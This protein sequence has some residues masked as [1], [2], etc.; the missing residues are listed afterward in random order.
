MSNTGAKYKI[1]DQQEFNTIRGLQSFGMTSKKIQ[2]HL[3]NNRHTSTINTLRNFDTLEEYRQHVR[4]N[5]ARSLA[6]APKVVPMTPE[7]T[8]LFE[9]KTPDVPTGLSTEGMIQPR[10]AA[11]F[12]TTEMTLRRIA[13]A[14]ERMADAWEAKPA[15]RRIF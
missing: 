1:L 7:N 11:T 2:E 15:K 3:G 12:S 14:L 4:D 9:S 10:P 8:P 13:S 5:K 6:K